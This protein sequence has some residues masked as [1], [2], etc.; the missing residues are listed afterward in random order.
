MLIQARQDQA[1]YARVEAFTLVEALFAITV[2]AMSIGGI[3]YGYSQANRLALWSS[4]SAAAQ[5]YALQG[6]EQARAA[7]WNPWDYSTNTGVWSEN[8]ITAPS[9]YMQVDLLDIPMKDYP[10]GTNGVITSSNSIFYVTNYVI[11]TPVT[12]YSGGTFAPNLRQIQSVA[13]WSFALEPGKTFSNTV[14]TLRA[15]DE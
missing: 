12:T 10:F 11:V 4:M 15:S 3:V 7:Q 9:T 1:R 5:S 8:Q 13:Y 2:L 6:L 14:I